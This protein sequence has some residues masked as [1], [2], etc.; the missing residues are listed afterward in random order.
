MI[1]NKK[2]EKRII[3]DLRGRNGHK[4]SKRVMRDMRSMKRHERRKEDRE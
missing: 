1:G 2:K 3:R 4:E